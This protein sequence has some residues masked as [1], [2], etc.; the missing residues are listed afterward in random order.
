MSKLFKG[1]SKVIICYDNDEAGQNGAKDLCC[2]IGPKAKR[3]LWEPDKAKG[4][5]LNDLFQECGSKN[6]FLKEI[7]RYV[8][9]AR[10]EVEAILKP[11]ISM[12]ESL[13]SRI[14]LD[15]RGEIVGISSGYTRLD[16]QFS[17]ISGIW[18]VGGKPKEG[19]T[20]FAGNIAIRTAERGYSTIYM[21]YENGS[22]NLLAKI[23]TNVFNLTIAEFRK[24][25]KEIFDLSKHKPEHARLSKMLTNLYIIRPS[26]KDAC[27]QYVS[28]QEMATSILEKYILF[29]QED[30]SC[31]KPIIFVIDSLQKL[32]ALNVNDRRLSVDSWLRAFE[33]IRDQYNV[34]FLIISEL[35]RGKYKKPTLEAFK[36]S[37][38]IEYTADV[39]LFLEKQG[40][41]ITLNTVANR[42][43]EIGDSIIY[44]A[45]FEHWKLNE[46]DDYSYRKERK[47]EK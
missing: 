17:G 37:G 26:M 29:L 19:K 38:D 24:K 31:T 44:T 23:F 27:E 1:I 3:M 35:S 8:A 11:S 2:F 15:A 9:L 5:D 34:T 14:E 21:D 39:A 36:E 43:G 13:K 7:S 30:S 20:T 47:N 41:V 28:A 10:A 22:L 45:D 16:R 33:C 12:I 46:M 40:S 18:F 32:P 42:N 6:E 4:Y 25:H